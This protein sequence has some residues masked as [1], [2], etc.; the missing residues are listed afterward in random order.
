MN[1]PE[2]PAPPDSGRFRAALHALYDALDDALARRGPVCQLSGRCCRFTEYGHTLFLSAPEAA[3]LLDEAPPPCRPLDQGASCP[4]Q[5][6]AG[7][8]T[9]RE[10]RPLGCRVYYCDSDYQADAAE[11]CETFLSRLK[12]LVDDHGLAWDYAPLH[13]HLHRAAADGQ[14]ATAADRVA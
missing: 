13:R 5:D 7:R 1:H 6:A 9:A 11:L 2:A 3:L 4:W 12:R 10:A 14:F 8:C